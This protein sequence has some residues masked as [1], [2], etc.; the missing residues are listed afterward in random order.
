M[1][2]FEE[3]DVTRNTIN[4]VVE[5]V[6]EIGVANENSVTMKESAACE[7]D[8][9]IEAANETKFG[10]YPIS[11]SNSESEASILS[12]GVDPL[13]IFEEINTAERANNTMMEA[14]F[15]FG[16]VGKDPI[17]LKVDTPWTAD[18]SAGVASNN[19]YGA[20]PAPRL[21]SKRRITFSSENSTSNSEKM[22][23]TESIEGSAID[24]NRIF[25]FKT[26]SEEDELGR[27]LSNAE[28]N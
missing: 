3:I 16:S 9:E 13:E 19:K 23:M 20:H 10:T 21:N 12:E 1:N 14:S 2:T 5:T 25:T 11:S 4:T 24:T 7:T 26:S 22:E 27:W 28:D 18:K 15:K 6:S 17:S 8:I